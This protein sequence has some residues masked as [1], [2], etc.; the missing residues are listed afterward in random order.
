MTGGRLRKEGAERPSFFKDLWE[1]P[2]VGL[3]AGFY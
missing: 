3:H 2:C 1:A